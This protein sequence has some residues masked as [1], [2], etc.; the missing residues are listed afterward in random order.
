MAFQT[1]E[2]KLVNRLRIIWL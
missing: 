2:F 1:K